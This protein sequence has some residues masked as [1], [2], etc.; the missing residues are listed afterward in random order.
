MIMNLSNLKRLNITI[1]KRN[2]KNHP[3]KGGFY[4][5]KKKSTAYAVVQ[6]FFK[7]VFAEDT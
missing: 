5:L 6:K 7:R 3:F 4:Y 2:N 1:I